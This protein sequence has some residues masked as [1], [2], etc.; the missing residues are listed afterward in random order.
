[1]FDKLKSLFK[2]K[3]EAPIEKI[4]PE[5]DT[6]KFVEGTPITENSF[7]IIENKLNDYYAKKRKTNQQ[8]LDEKLA[9]A[10]LWSEFT[11]RKIEEF[12]IPKDIIGTVHTKIDKLDLES[13]CLPSVRV[14]FSYKLP[15]MIKE[16][17]KTFEVY[18]KEHD[19]SE[20]SITCII[21]NLRSIKKALN[22]TLQNKA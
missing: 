22:E 12:G 5:V 6:S 16:E 17:T 11:L 4:H 15:D 2:K 9:I 18:V 13:T 10:R 21:E 19:N 7:K 3:K 20:Y 14:C 8:V 1:M